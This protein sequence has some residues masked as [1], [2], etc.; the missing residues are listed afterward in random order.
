MWYK[1][2]AKI[3]PEQAQLDMFAQLHARPR[4]NLESQAERVRRM[5][6]QPSNRFGKL[7]G[8]RDRAAKA[9]QKSAEVTAKLRAAEQERI[10]KH[11][12]YE[13]ARQTSPVSSVRREMP[14]YMPPR[15]PLS[16][17]RPPPFR[18]TQIPKPM[19]AP[20]RWGMHPLPPLLGMPLQE[21]GSAMSSARVLSLV[22]PRGRSSMASFD[23][24]RGM[25]TSSKPPPWLDALVS[26]RREQLVD[27]VH[28]G[29]WPPYTISVPLSW[30]AGSAGESV[31]E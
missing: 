16:D 22:S 13:A 10:A 21:A 30:S 31:L 25:V 28:S 8:R 7:E 12:A 27:T 23:Q 29:K 19:T 18:P 1:E 3:S 20:L 17:C 5:E 26:P 11:A 2:C 9:N 14:A 4:V 6:R 24:Y 15:I